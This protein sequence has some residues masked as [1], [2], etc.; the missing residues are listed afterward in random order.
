MEKNK[1]LIAQH[2][3]FDSEEYQKLDVVKVLNGKGLLFSFIF[4]GLF[5]TT[6]NLISLLQK[7]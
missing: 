3:Y 2:D 4:F 1:K 6:P 5:V 7:P